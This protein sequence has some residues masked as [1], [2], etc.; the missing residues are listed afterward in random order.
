MA[1]GTPHRVVDS[2]LDS[3]A[4]G[5]KSLV[6]GVTSA[7]E[8]LGEGV[9]KGLDTPWKAMG[10]PDQPLRIVDRLFDGALH[11]TVNA[12]NQGGI[13]TLKMGGES[14]QT[15]LDHPVESFGIPPELGAGMGRIKMPS[16]P[17]GK[18]LGGFKPPW[19]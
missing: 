4:D 12:V 7:L 10:G 17:L 6:S 14:V 15:G 3:A 18:G 16:S 9:Q 13:E 5:A 8:G 11:A 2:I 1:D 19:E